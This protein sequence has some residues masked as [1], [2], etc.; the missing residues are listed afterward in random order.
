MDYVG[1]AG[2]YL[3]DIKYYMIKKSN[4]KEKKKSRSTYQNLR[5][6]NLGKWGENVACKFLKK[7]GFLIYKTNYICKGGEIDII[8]KKN[9][10]I[11]FIEVKTRSNSNF[12][13]ALEAFSESKKKHFWH[14]VNYY[15]LENNIL[16]KFQVDLITINVMNNKAILKHYKNVVLRDKDYW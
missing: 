9:N 8:A 11:H 13:D 1:G 10:L 7:R 16:D 3:K 6:S 5:K 15:L 2:F 4:L 14:A 12:G